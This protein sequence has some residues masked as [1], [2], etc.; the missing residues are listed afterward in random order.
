MSYKD[1]MYRFT[2][3]SKEAKDPATKE[4]SLALV[5]LVKLIEK[6]NNKT[7]RLAAYAIQLAQ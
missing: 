3:V 7:L 5:D 6:D 1:L 4:I 2:K